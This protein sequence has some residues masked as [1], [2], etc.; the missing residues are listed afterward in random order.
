MNC[1]IVTDFAKLTNMH[2]RWKDSSK[3]S[4][5]C[6]D[7]F[8]HWE[9][10]DAF[11]KTH[12]HTLSL[13]SPVVYEGDQIRGILP[14]A[15]QNGTLL[16][17]GSSE[18][19]YNDVLCDDADAQK[20][21]PAAFDTL[22]AFPAWNICILD[23]LPADSKL[24]RYLHLLRKD[25][26]SNVHLF[27]RSYCPTIIVDEVHQAL[28]ALIGK[29]HLR[30]DEARLQKMGKLTFRHLEAR[31]SIRLHMNDFFRQHIARHAMTGI[32]SHFLDP[33]CREFYTALV[34][35]LDPCSEL[36]FAVLELNS[37]ALAYH[38]GYQL[39]G[40]LTVYQPTFDIDYWEYSPGEVLL[41]GLLRY[42]RDNGIRE[43]DFSQGDEIYKRRF[44]N[45]VKSTYVLS[46]EKHR[47]S[48]RGLWVRSIWQIREW[49]RQRPALFHV[50][51]EHTQQASRFAGH[52]RAFVKLGGIVGLAK[53]CWQSGAS[54]LRNALFARSDINVY[55]CAV[56][57][58]RAAAGP[59][60]RVRSEI[61]VIPATLK[62]LAIC[63]LKHPLLLNKARLREFRKRLQNRDRV[64]LVCKFDDVFGLIWA[65]TRNEV[66]LSNVVRER[67]DLL[68][69]PAV[70]L[71]D[72]RTV[73]GALKDVFEST[74]LERVLAQERN[75]EAWIYCRSA[76]RASR[77][78]IEKAG[79]EL[80]YQLA[81][82]PFRQ[83]LHS[84][85]SSTKAATKSEN[86]APQG[87]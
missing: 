20:V 50:V 74:V 68:Q 13:C 4:H 87:A 76:D 39:N 70:V 16:F 18:S 66:V 42:A 27:F 72:F 36:R 26:Q 2:Q 56:E 47:N 5:L 49:G 25:L 77:R 43:V 14:L 33:K 11:W 38:F 10:I 22:L 62:D 12:R 6:S 71:Y 53:F 69:A 85:C 31:D 45:H 75:S 3:D 78:E 81:R 58:P 61:E 51:K 54:L 8:Q 9:W 48:L 29:K 59:S 65:G 23:N 84:S 60:G 40:K 86:H 24:V 79:F 63:S 30:R 35:A 21:L 7:I 17:I 28:D 52:I 19:D 73:P 34:E 80:R 46:F 57:A 67:K 82:A 32:R 55:Q 83:W 15:I 64:Y 1:E 41:K 37:R 44:A